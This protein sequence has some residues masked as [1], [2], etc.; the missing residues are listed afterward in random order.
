V[1]PQ[2]EDHPLSP[3]SHYGVSKLAGERYVS[4]YNKMYGLNTTILRYFHVYGPRQEYNEFGGVVA[5]FIRNMLKG[6]RPTI[7]GDGT[8]ERSF[9]YVRDIVRANQ[10]TAV[11]DKAQGEVFNCASGIKVTINW[12]AEAVIRHFG[13]SEAVAPA[14]KDWL[15]GDIKVF[16]VDNSKIQRLGVVFER[17][18]DA[19]LKETIMMMRG[20][21]T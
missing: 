12:L 3:V 16:D 21:I 11:S 14:Y 20:Y 5:I 2:T 19:K 17:D 6:E 18:F 15:P 13:K 9:T 10:L 8:Q 4:L 7:F 1:I